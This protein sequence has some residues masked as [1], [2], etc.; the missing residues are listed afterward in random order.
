MR[1]DV[2]LLEG[3]R[4]NAKCRCSVLDDAERGL[5][6]LAHHFTELVG[7]DQPAAARRVR[8]PELFIT[9]AVLD[10]GDVVARPA[11]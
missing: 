5:R 2:A 9:A 6:T 8:G 7:E 4:I 1:V 11:K 3:R 10:C